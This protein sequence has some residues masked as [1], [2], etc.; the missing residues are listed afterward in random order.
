MIWRLIITP[1][2]EH[3]FSRL[4]DPEKQ[5]IKNELY[6]LA[7]EEYPRKRLKKLKG[8][9]DSPLYALRVGRFRIILILEDENMVIIVIEMG[10]RSTVYRKV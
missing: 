7:D 1:G 8:N 5:R 4:S 9:R 3:D 10:R 2:A 6:T